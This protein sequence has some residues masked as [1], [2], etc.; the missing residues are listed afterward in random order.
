MSH[1]VNS[2]AVE[3]IYGIYFCI[4]VYHILDLIF[5]FRLVL[6]VRSSVYSLELSH[7]D[8]VDVVCWT[9]TFLLL[10][11]SF[12]VR[13]RQPSIQA[14]FSILVEININRISSVLWRKIIRAAT[15]QKGTSICLKINFNKTNVMV[16]AKQT[17]NININTDGKSIQQAKNSPLG[18]NVWRR[19]L[20]WHW[21]KISE[22]NWKKGI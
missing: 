18:P 12:S 19:S 21:S 7:V 3:L 1:V 20:M 17:K 10:H 11:D 5:I 13:R 4:A 9:R 8:G 15:H 16:I 14:D 22:C 6:C 2:L